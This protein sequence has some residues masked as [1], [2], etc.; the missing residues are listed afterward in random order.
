MSIAFVFLT[1]EAGSEG[2]V[3]TNLRKL[4]EVKE[5]YCVYGI[6]DIV[7]KVKANSMDEL[8]DLIL[9]KVRKINRIRSTLTIILLE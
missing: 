2:E 8:K 6:Y 9:S 3:L 1:T 7:I 5:A 4:K